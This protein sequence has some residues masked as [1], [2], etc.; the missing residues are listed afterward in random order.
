MPRLAPAPVRH[1]PALSGSGRAS[2]S[3]SPPRPHPILS[4]RSLAHP[5]LST[6]RNALPSLLIPFYPFCGFCIPTPLYTYSISSARHPHCISV[7]SMPFRASPCLSM[8]LLPLSSPSSPLSHAH[9]YPSISV[10]LP[11]SPAG[12]AVLESK[13]EREWEREGKAEQEQHEQQE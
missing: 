7:F 5:R 10:P 3:R 2:A 1:C 9:P 13:G 12:S 8:P 4:V 11:A 6:A